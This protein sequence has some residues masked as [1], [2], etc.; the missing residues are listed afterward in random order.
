LV[1]KRPIWL[2][3]AA[4]PAIARSPTTQRIAGSRH[5]RSA[6]FTYFVAGQPPEHRLPQQAGEP[7]PT[8]LARARVGQC[9]GTSVGQVERVIQLAISQQSGIG[10]DRRTAKSQQ[11]TA[12]EIEPQRAVVRFTR[13]VPIAALFDPR[14][15]LNFT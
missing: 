6:S 11:Q 12:V 15:P 13:R 14:K 8:V 7:V 3:E 10:G 5:S 9:F 2:A 1:S 4:E